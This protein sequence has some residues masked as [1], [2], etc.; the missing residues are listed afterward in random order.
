[1]GLGDQAGAET[2]FVQFVR[3]F[4]E[5]PLVHSVMLRIGRLH[6][7]DIPKDAEAVWKVAQAKQQT[8]QAERERQAAL[9]A[10]ECLAHLLPGVPVETLAKEM[11]TDGRGTS[12]WSFVATAHRHGFAGAQGVRLTE[13]GLRKQTLPV[14]ALVAPGH[15]VVVNKITDNGLTVWDGGTG[16]G[17]S[18]VVPWDKWR[19]L[20]Q[21][22]QM[23]GAFSNGV[24]VR[25]LA[26]NGL[27][28]KGNG[29]RL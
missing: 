27:A 2:E 7:G 4:P 29:S 17:T 21:G 28:S 26:G 12:V 22:G 20:W 8:A 3:D 14:V 15:F 24:A 19:Q 6:G 5:S 11:A 10:P 18:R 25:G 1:M 23:H 13:A 16:A 9:C